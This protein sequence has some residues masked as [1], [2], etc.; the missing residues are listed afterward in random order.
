MAGAAGAAGRA[1]LK[2]CA[3]RRRRRKIGDA[4][5]AAR[6]SAEFEKRAES[7]GACIPRKARGC[8]VWRKQ[9]KRGRR[10]RYG[11]IVQRVVSPALL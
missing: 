3:A 9:Q 6:A 7:R 8:V 5:I 2:R 10:G 11:H 4:L 1:V